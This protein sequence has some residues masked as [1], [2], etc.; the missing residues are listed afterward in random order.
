MNSLVRRFNTSIVFNFQQR[1]GGHGTSV[2]TSHV[3]ENSKGYLLSRHFP[4]E[5]VRQRIENNRLD[6]LGAR[7]YEPFLIDSVGGDT[8]AKILEFKVS[9]VRTLR[10]KNGCGASYISAAAITDVGVLLNGK[11]L[12]RLRSISIRSSFKSLRASY[13]TV[14][15]VA[16]ASI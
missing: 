6:G 1:L 12:S 8:E 5:Q 14:G 15:A 7:L 4:S 2:S 13:G 11:M 16:A 3:H 10:E 9:G